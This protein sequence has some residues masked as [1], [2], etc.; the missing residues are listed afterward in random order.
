[1]QELPY[2]WKWFLAFISFKFNIYISTK[3]LIPI[4]FLL[5]TLAKKTG[6]IWQHCW[7]RRLRGLSY[8]EIV[9]VWTAVNGHRWGLFVLKPRS[10]LLDRKS[11]TFENYVLLYYYDVNCSM[12]VMQIWQHFAKD[13]MIQFEFLIYCSQFVNS[14]VRICVTILFAINNLVMLCLL[15]YPNICFWL[16]LACS[17]TKVVKMWLTFT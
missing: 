14:F 4:A 5:K 7:G 12:I 16:K 2:L 15:H 10:K 6:P 11:N 13:L 1:M 8:K 3:R 17:S 9:I